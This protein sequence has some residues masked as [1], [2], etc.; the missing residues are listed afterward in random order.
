[1]YILF[2]FVIIYVIV[3]PDDY[4]ISASLPAG[5]GQDLRGDLAAHV[6]HRHPLEDQVRGQRQPSAHV[7]GGQVPAHLHTLHRQGHRR[8]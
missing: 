8:S 2:M 5:L 6:L 1:M 4:P 3:L 7:R